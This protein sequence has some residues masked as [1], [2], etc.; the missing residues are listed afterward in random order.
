[1]KADITPRPDKLVALR[2]EERRIVGL[3][4]IEF[5]EI[6]RDLNQLLGAWLFGPVNSDILDTLLVKTPI[7]ARIDTAVEFK[8]LS[9]DNAKVFRSLCMERNRL[10]HGPLGGKTIVDIFPVSTQEKFIRQ[11]KQLKA[12][13]AEEF[14]EVLEH[15]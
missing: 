1:M 12:A 10:A 4:L 8:L 6:E 5:F 13:I 15:L 11:C 9:S 14:E 7:H 2:E 3:L